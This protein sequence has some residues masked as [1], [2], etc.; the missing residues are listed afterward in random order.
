MQ[1]L[2]YL[3]LFLL[4]LTPTLFAQDSRHVTFHYGFTVKNL[5]AGKK[6]RVWIPAAPS[7]E[8]QDVKVVSAKGDLPL[9]HTR[10]SEHGNEMYFAETKR[11]SATDLHF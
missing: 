3:L 4:A 6:A 11:N 8:F 10:E 5:P 2:C 9:K 7:D 1:R